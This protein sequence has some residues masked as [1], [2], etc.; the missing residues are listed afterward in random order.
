MCSRR[1]R[2]F[3]GTRPPCGRDRDNVDVDVVTQQAEAF[4]D[5]STAGFAIVV[6]GLRKRYG[7]LVAVDGISFRVKDREIFGLLG[8]NGAGR[9]TTVEILEGLRDADD[10]RAIVAR[11]DARK[12][13]QKYKGPIELQLQASA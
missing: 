10:G 1:S 12:E 2:T 9:T 4:P 8:T 11:I 7:S 13:P 5:A 6:D 3:R